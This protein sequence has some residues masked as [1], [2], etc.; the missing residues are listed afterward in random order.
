M[1]APATFTVDGQ[2]HL[3]LLVGSPALPKEGPAAEPTTVASR[4]NS[5]LLIYRI[6]GEAQLPSNPVTT[7]ADR[8]LKYRRSRPLMN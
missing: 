8:N 4:N 2:Q 6:G 7:S 1:A 5:R 3:A